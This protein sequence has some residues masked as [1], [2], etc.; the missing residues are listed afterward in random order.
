MQRPSSKNLSLD[1]DEIEYRISDQGGG[2]VEGPPSL[3]T[4]AAAGHRQ[5]F[6][7]WVVETRFSPALSKTPV[8][9]RREKESAPDTSCVGTE[10]SR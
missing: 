9:L 10:K 4:A 2:E 7:F 3:T 1:Q 6:R 5:I 8:R